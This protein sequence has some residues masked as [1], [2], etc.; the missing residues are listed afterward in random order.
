MKRR[1]EIIL[2]FAVLCFVNTNFVLAGDSRK[3]IS[4]LTHDFSNA[5]DIEAEIRF[6]R[7]LSARILGNY[8]LLKD[9]RINHY[10]GLVGTGISQYSGRPELKFYFAVLESNEVNAFASPGGYIFITQGALM[11][12]ENEAQLAAVL[13]HEIAHVVMRHVVNSLKIRGGGDSAEKGIASLIG[14]STG[15]FREAF[16]RSLDEAAEILFEKGYK[17]EEEIE[18]DRVGIL[19]AASAGYDPSALRDFLIKIKHFETDNKKGG[20]EHPSYRIRMQEI[21][22][23]VVSNSL[24]DVKNAK[25]RKRF[26]EYIK[27]NRS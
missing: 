27:S 6:G 3:R 8:S 4:S 2:F 20:S 19:I 9:E 23:T 1:N 11:E 25:V 5:S 15:S 24:M 17:I 21:E 13:G 22:K 10:V 12:M 18:A 16:E 26:Y 14:G 7:N